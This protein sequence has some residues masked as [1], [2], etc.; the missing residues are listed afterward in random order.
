[1]TKLIN[2]FTHENRQ[3]FCVSFDK[4]SRNARN[5]IPI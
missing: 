2:Q 3:L 1:M 5:C 4:V